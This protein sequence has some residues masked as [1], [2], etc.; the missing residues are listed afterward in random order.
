MNVPLDAGPGLGR[1]EGARMLRIRNP[2]DLAAG[3]LLLVFAAGVL[4]FGRNLS[5][6]L[7]SRMGPGYIPNLLAW[8]I[9]AFGLLIALRGM[10]VDGR[11]LEAWPLKPIVLILGATLIFGQAIERFG[12]V[13]AAALLIAV[14]SVAAPDYRW[15]ESLVFAA[16]LT[17]LS[18]VL[19]PL[20]LGLS[21]RIWP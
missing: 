15:R 6:G 14:A 7:A 8:A 5:V 17:L 9:A 13:I 10:A 21:L 2:R 19:F 12:L 11:R 4:W 18:V 3:L 16:A 1:H 20:A